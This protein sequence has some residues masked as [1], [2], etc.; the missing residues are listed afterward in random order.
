VAINYSV[1]YDGE[2]YEMAKRTNIV[3]NQKKKNAGNKLLGW[4]IF[5]IGFGI[6]GLII[7]TTGQATVTIDNETLP[8]DAFSSDAIPYYVMSIA[9]IIGGYFMIAKAK[10]DQQLYNEYINIIIDSNITSLHDIASSLNKKVSV[11]TADIEKMINKNRLGNAY[12]DY[13][14]K[15]I[16]F[17]SKT[18]TSTSTSKN[19][20]FEQTKQT[21]SVTCPSCGGKNT[22]LY[23][24][25]SRCEYCGST[26]K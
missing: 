5:L 10:K 4:G 8:V 19:Q 23:G 20:S 14:E 16:V 3:I 13:K 17:P 6:I 24:T 1:F 12:I 2:G 26:L 18:S 21:V 22:V 7:V 15:Q 11:V 9:S 25:V